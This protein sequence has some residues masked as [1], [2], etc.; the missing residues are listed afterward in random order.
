MDKE[1]EIQFNALHDHINKLT[2]MV[3]RMAGNIEDLSDTVEAGFNAMIGEEDVST[4]ETA[5]DV[6]APP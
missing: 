3:A 1:L 5:R 4:E 6:Q 2:R